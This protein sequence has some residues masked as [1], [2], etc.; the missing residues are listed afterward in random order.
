[1]IQKNS[2]LKVIDNSGVKTVCCISIGKGFNKKSAKLG[3]IILV[4][5]KSLRTKRKLYSKI[6][7]GEICKALI[8]RTK[9]KIVLSRWCEHF[10]FTENSVVLFTKQEKFL[11]TRVFGGISN[12]FRYSKYLRIIS[13]SSGLL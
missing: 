2:Y 4:S 3:D 5:V 1:M 13:L 11:F 10:Y 6:K 12:F 7:K 8:V 9:N